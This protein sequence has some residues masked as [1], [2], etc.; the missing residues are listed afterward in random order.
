MAV[1]V[2]PEGGEVLHLRF[3]TRDGVVVDW[4]HVAHVLANQ[5]CVGNTLPV[6]Y[7][8]RYPRRCQP[9]AD[10]YSNGPREILWFYAGLGSLC[11]ASALLN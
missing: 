3:T 8:P 7:L 2:A 10:V 9:L 5:Y 6:R 4:P 1:S 11:L